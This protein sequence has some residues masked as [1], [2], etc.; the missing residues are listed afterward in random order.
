MTTSIL[1]IARAAAAAC[2]LLLAAATPAQAQ[3][4]LARTAAAAC[5]DLADQ[6]HAVL[7]PLMRERGVEA[8]VRV[9]FTLQRGRVQAAQV[10]GAPTAY[11]R[12]V[13]RALRGVLCAQPHAEGQPMTVDIVF[14][15]PMQQAQRTASATLLAASAASR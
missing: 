15:D 5:P 8:R 4:Q 10:Q 14:V 3:A 12:G 6:L 9:S 2:L 7:D 13:R 1:H 11:D